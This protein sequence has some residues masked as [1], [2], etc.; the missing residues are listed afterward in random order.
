MDTNTPASREHQIRR[1]EENFHTSG[2]AHEFFGS[3]FRVLKITQFDPDVVDKF[4][5]TSSEFA[6]RGFRSLAVAIKEEGKDWQLLGIMSMQ[7]P[8]RPDSA[9]T[10][11]EAQDLGINIKMLTG[12]AVAIA[13]ELAKQ[14]GL[15]T[16][17][18]DSQKLIGGTLNGSEIRDF[19]EAAD[20]FAEVYPEHKYQVVEML[21]QRGPSFRFDKR[22][23]AN[24]EVRAFDGDDGRRSERCPK[25]EESRLWYRC[26]GCFRCCA[27]VRFEGAEDNYSAT[28]AYADLTTSSAADV[29]FLDEGLNS[30]ITSI[31]VARQIFHRMKSYIV[32]RTSRVL[33]L[34]ESLRSFLY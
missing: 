9:S 10:I 22:N 7:D 11:R 34:L 26:G 30:I 19:V 31:K 4:Q 3:P 1:P 23:R 16:N 28:T 18:Y 8:P 33:R 25:F 32:Y 20:G 24:L 6:R 13:K 5:E 2:F 14:L 15:G 21:Q 29:V 17:V 12:D 27:K